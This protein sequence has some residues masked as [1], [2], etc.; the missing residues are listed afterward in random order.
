MER[1]RQ[2]GLRKDSAM[3]ITGRSSSLLALVNLEKNASFE[4]CRFADPADR[5]EEGPK[6]L[7]E[8]RTEKPADCKLIS[9]V[10]RPS[11]EPSGAE[12]PRGPAKKAVAPHP[13]QSDLQC[14]RELR[15]TGGLNPS[16]S[17][18]SPLPAHGN[19]HARYP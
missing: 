12:P 8:L 10:R 11:G 3:R 2:A 17:S 9:R 7:R 5:F 6:H 16:R 19:V 13:D 15:G 4:A 14:H 18:E 1:L